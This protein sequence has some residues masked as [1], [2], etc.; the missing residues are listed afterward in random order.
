MGTFSAASHH[1]ILV[2]LIQLATLL[3]TARL[4]AE[5]A[6]RLGQPPVLGEILAGILLGP[7]LLSGLVPVVGEWLVP[8]TPLQWHLLEVVALLGA[9]FLLLITGL[10]TDLALIRRHARTAIGVSVGGILVTFASGF[11]LGQALPDSLLQQPSSRL[12]FS[13]FIATAMSI[14]AIP[15]IAKVLM[16]LK[17]MRRDIGQTIIASGMSDDTVGWILLSVVAGLASG[18]AMG[19][20]EIAGAVGKVLAFIILSLTVGRWLLRKTLAFV[21]DE[22]AGP[23]RILSFVVMCA[24]LWGAVSQALGLEAV[25]GAFVVGIVFGQMARLSEEVRHRL[26]AVALGIFAPIFF[27]VAGLKVNVRGLLDPTFALITLAVIAVA[28]VGKVVGTYAGARLIG[29]RDHWSALSFGAGL[30]ARGAMEIIIATIGLSLGILSQDMFSIIVIMAM[31]T[32]LM[33]PFALRWTLRHVTPSAEETERLKREQQAKE[34]L[35][36]R[37]HRVLV[38]LRRRPDQAAGAHAIEAHMLRRFA[39]DKPLAITLL[40]VCSPGERDAS[41]SYLEKVA[42]LFAG[43]EVTK[44]VVEGAKAELAI[45]EEAQKG[46]DLIV[47]G[48]TERS[49]TSDSLFNPIVDLIVRAAPCP[50]MIVRGSAEKPRWPPSRILVPTNGSASSKYAAEFGFALPRN[51]D[52]EVLILNVIA[53]GPTSYRLDPGGQIQERE[54]AIAHAIV[55][56]LRELGE[57]KGVRIDA[58]VRF[59]RDPESVIL[60]VAQKGEVGLI[61]IGTDVRVGSAKLFLGPRVERILTH[62]PCPVAILNAS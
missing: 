34:S 48:A 41:A 51:N 9:M 19:A 4:L 31:A 52:D 2:L 38:P 53:Q 11:A 45:L 28:T 62:A 56:E 58:D 42:V 18:K 24:L 47:L 26:E 39:K 49:G 57:A 33:A 6:I 35:L 59:G 10:E 25:L 12:I 3:F 16:D 32:S 61:I 46:Y 14:S 27:A 36:A 60:K 43:A 20:T 37:I 1:D 8:E 17:L 30:N 13:L 15:V 7:S 54:L 40:T 21:Q 23:N 29:R 55:D 50:T 5:I 22:L 44:K